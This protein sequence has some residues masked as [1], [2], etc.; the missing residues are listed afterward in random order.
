MLLLFYF[1]SVVMDTNNKD[2]CIS[3]ILIFTGYQIYAGYDAKYLTEVSL[4]NPNT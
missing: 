1:L 4:F 2:H 3:I